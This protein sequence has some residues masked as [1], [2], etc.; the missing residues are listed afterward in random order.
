MKY[1]TILLMCLFACFCALLC[2]K[3]QKITLEEITKL[4]YDNIETT[5]DDA[6]WQIHASVSPEDSTHILKFT[7]KGEMGLT[8]E[9]VYCMVVWENHKT[10]EFRLIAPWIDKF[11]T[12]QK[13]NLQDTNP[14][15]VPKSEMR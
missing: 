15:L 14:E 8:Q 2:Q 11:V 4:P 5:L 6:D 1:S 10:N 3:E 9:V 13:S 7:Y 12:L